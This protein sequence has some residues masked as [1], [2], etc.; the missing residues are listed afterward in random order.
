M[1]RYAGLI[2]ASMAWDRLDRLLWEG[3]A[4]AA[5]R[6]LP[7]VDAGH[8]ALA[9]A[10]MLLRN[11]APGVD[12]A[13]AKVPDALTSDP[14][15]LY[16]RLRWR[17]LHGNDEGVLEILAAAPRAIPYPDLWAEE[18][19]IAARRLLEA[20]DDRGAYRV[21][22]DHYELSGA[23]YHEIEWLA[24]WIALRK[25]GDAQAALDHFMSFYSEVSFPISRARGA[26]WAGRAA[27]ALGGTGIATVWY[28][29]AADHGQTFYGQ[30][31]AA[32]IG[33]EP[34][35]PEAPEPTEAELE[36]FTRDELTAVVRQLHE[37]DEEQLVRVFLTRMIEAA[38][39]PAR[40]QLI[41]Q[42]ALVMGRPDLAVLVA[43]E[44]VKAGTVLVTAG[45]PMIALPSEMPIDPA[46]AYAVM[47]QES[48]FDPGAI[49][50][51]GARG[52]M[53]LM[54]AT[55]QEIAGKLG[56]ATSNDKLTSDPQHNIRLGSAYLAAMIRGQGGSFVRAVA[57]YNAGPGRVREWVAAMGDPHDPST[58]IVDW[59]EEI[60]FSETRNY[61]QR[62]LEGMEIYRML[63]GVRTAGLMQTMQTQ[64]AQ[65]C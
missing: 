40:H 5:Q 25:L 36:A 52:L 19:L 3:N 43:K 9:R 14:G 7:L 34:R 2:P 23:I 6:I 28:D 59:I 20:G 32:R 58:D 45:Y 57:A 39:S 13:I 47:R 65:A 33:I 17:R 44:A 64:C 29:L 49:S 51:A 42:L 41:G 48:A 63:Q 1:E 37:I 21:L 31:G 26:Y 22:A 60:P 62:V 4:N 54:P 16:E 8:Q 27:E 18:R 11:S 56:L 10:R 35:L 24:G 53:Q 30:L 55:A 61:V 12:G 38:A 46:L 50:P 15:L